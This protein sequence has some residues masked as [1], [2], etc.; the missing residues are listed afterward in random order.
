MRFDGFFGVKWGSMG[1]MCFAEVQSVSQW[2]FKVHLGSVRFNEVRLL[3]L[4]VKWG[5]MCSMWFVDVQNGLQG[6][7]EVHLGSV[8]FN[9]VR[10]FFGCQMG[11][12]GFSVVC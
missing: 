8:R 4:W 11:F 6:F 10:W 7:F 12:Y 9:E 5:S 3:F 2:F 1:S